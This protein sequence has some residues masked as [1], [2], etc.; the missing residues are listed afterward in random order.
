MPHDNVMME[1]EGSK[2]STIKQDS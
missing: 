2:L 1:R